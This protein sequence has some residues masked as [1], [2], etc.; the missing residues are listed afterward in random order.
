MQNELMAG[1]DI[2]SPGGRS[3][4][5]WAKCKRKFKGTTGRSAS[6]S[7]N[8]LK[9]QFPL[10]V[11]SGFVMKLCFCTCVALPDVMQINSSSSIGVLHFSWIRPTEFDALKHDPPRLDEAGKGNMVATSSTDSGPAPTSSL[12]TVE[13]RVSLPLSFRPSTSQVVAESLYMSSFALGSAEGSCTSSPPLDDV[14]RSS[15]SFSLG[16]FASTCFR[17]VSSLAPELSFV[18]VSSSSEISAHFGISFFVEPPV[19]KALSS[20]SRVRPF[21]IFA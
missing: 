13:T 5:S 10:N 18:I 11:I 21:A 9:S 15:T 1:S 12:R 4:T 8:V 19:S 3:A 7:I 6:A 2:A 14:T 20:H 17:S 16:I